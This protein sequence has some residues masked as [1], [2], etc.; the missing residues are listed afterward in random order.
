MPITDELNLKL[1]RAEHHIRDL[2]RLWSEFVE[3]DAYP[4]VHHDDL[5]SGYRLYRLRYASPVPS[6]I[7]LILGDAVH[8][9]RSVLDHLIYRLIVIATNGTGPFGGAYFPVG[10]T[11]AKFQEALAR[12]SECKSKTGGKIQRLRQ[13]AMKAITTIQPYEGGRGVLL[14]NIHQLDIRDKHYVLLAVGSSNPKHSSL[15]SEVADIK[16]KFLGIENNGLTPAMASKV[17][18]RSSANTVFPLKTGAELLRVPLSEV[19]ENMYF[20]FEVAFGEPE[21]LK[22]KPIVATLYRAAQLTRNIIRDFN[23]HGLFT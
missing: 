8:N 2:K 23:G 11:L 13:D 21:I 7:P 18:L 16:K 12:T 19:D 10:E 15:P 22:G 5:K 4:F 20:T 17:Y 14:W 6:D 9:L 3:K 1:E